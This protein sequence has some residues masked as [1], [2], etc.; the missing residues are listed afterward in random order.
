MGWAIDPKLRLKANWHN[1][2][3]LGRLLDQELMNL[4]GKISQGI[5]IGNDVSF[6]L[7]EI[8]LAQVDR[9]LGLKVGRA[10]RWYD[11]YEIAC[12]TYDEAQQILARLSRELSAF[13]LRINPNKTKITPLPSPS[14]EEW[15]Q[16]IREQSEPDLN[17]PDNL[18]QYFD[19]AFR[20][21]RKSPESPILLYALAVLFKLLCPNIPTGR[22]ALSAVSQCLL[23][24]PGAAQKAFSLLTFW[25]LNGFVLDT[26]LLQQTVER[27]ILRHEMTGI[28]SDIS[29]A[30][31][32]CIENNI[33]LSTRA[34]RILSV[35]EDDCVRI[36]ALHA[37]QLGLLPTGFSTA[38][39]ARLLK[40]VDL[41]GEHWLLGYEAFRHGFLTDSAAAVNANPLFE[42]LYKSNVTFYR[43]NLPV[44]ASVIHPGGAPEW[45]V[46]QWITSL[47]LKKLKGVK[48][49][50]LQAFPVLDLVRQDLERVSKKQASIE[51]AIAEL[52]DLREPKATG[53]IAGVEPYIG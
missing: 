25:R 11:D 1:K 10:F 49:K 46:Q 18:V 41:D 47:R 17:K 44:Y 40:T 30:L 20:L 14:Q 35:F 31:A 21:H 39:I 42:S 5:P 33:A 37:H 36:Q 15:Q 24:E 9:K 34:S 2:K 22:V 7:T 50:E 43:T 8:V 16:I 27:M 6:L 28:S 53:L 32:F 52:L 4:Q 3:L 23:A 12:D 51:D 29:W 48:A 13:R 19:T 26:Q 38:R 45:A